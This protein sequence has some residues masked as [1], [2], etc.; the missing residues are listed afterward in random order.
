[1]YVFV[2]FVYMRGALKLFSTQINALNT[3]KVPPAPYIYYVC[4]CGALKLYS[5][6]VNALSTFKGPPAPYIYYVC[7]LFAA[8]EHYIVHTYYV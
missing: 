8:H 4:F 5:A 7:R 3:F 2:L 1:M 6:T